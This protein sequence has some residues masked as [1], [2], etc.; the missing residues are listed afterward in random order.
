MSENIK[1]GMRMHDDVTHVIH[2]Y[3][4]DVD[5]SNESD[6]LLF[7]MQTMFVAANLIASPIGILIED[8][9]EKKID[10]LVECLIQSAKEIAKNYRDIKKAT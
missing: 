9:D 4:Q 7:Q 8:G 10:G 2:M 1:R 5:A 3:A 6:W